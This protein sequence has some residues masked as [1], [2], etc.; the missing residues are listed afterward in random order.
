MSKITLSEAKQ[1]A[2]KS[3]D[4]SAYNIKLYRTTPNE[5]IFLCEAKDRGMTPGT[6]VVAVN[7]ATGKLG[8]SLLS[9]E[10]AVEFSRK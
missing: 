2:A 7:G 6:V 3:I 8:S 9:V 4:S 10:E 5:Y 1:I